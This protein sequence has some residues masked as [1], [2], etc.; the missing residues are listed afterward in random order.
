MQNFWLQEIKSD[1][2]SYN[3]V[4]NVGTFSSDKYFSYRQVGIYP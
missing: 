2:N 4:G 3:F 1:D